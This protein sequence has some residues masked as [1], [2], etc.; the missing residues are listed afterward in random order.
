MKCWD[1]IWDQENIFC[2]KRGIYLKISA[3]AQYAFGAQFSVDNTFS[4]E[5]SIK[6][7]NN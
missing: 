5:K 1:K 6:T 4:V 7:R 2:T 3:M